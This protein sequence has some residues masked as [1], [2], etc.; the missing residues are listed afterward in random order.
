MA[1]M[2]EQFVLL[3][4]LFAFLSAALAPFGKATPDKAG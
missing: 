1:E 2:M 3:A 4:R